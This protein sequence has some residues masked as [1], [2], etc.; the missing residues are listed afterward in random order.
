MFRRA[1]AVTTTLDLRQWLLATAVALSVIVAAEIRKA[2][3]RGTA[4]KGVPP[5]Q[6]GRSDSH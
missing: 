1:Q 2:G 4:A 5:A 6:P 3:L